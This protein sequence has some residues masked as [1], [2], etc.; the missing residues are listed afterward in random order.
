[1]LPAAIE[2][3]TAVAAARRPDPVVRLASGA[4]S[5]MAEVRLDQPPRPGEPRRANYLLGG[6]AGFPARGADLP[7]FDAAGASTVAVGGGLSSSA[8][9]EVATATLL[10]R[11]TGLTLPGEEKALLCQRA[12]HEYA[13]VPCGIMDQFAAVFGRRDHLLLLDCR[14]RQIS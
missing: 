10:E 14:S 13:G 1:V 8:A 6:L 4:A 9:L 2:R 5:G 11:L 3:W 7:G 12:E